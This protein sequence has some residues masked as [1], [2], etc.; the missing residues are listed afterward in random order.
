[1]WAA[2]SDERG[3]MAR[4]DPYPKG[5]AVEVRW[6][7]SIGTGHWGSK[8]ETKMECVTVGLLVERRKDRIVLAMSRSHYGDGH[9]WE[10]P[11]CSIRRVR[12]LK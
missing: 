9:H 6:I 5:A 2:I 8:P 11:A 10:I 12:R 1:M 7:D 3:S 4:N